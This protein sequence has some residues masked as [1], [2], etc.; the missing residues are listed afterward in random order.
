MIQNFSTLTHQDKA[1]ILNNRVN[2][3]LDIDSSVIQNANDNIHLVLP[4]GD[5]S[6]QITL[7]GSY[8]PDMVKAYAIA[9]GSDS[10]VQFL[11]DCDILRGVVTCK[12]KDDNTYTVDIRWPN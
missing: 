7:T 2:I 1:D 12:R 4:K 5:T 11:L 10:W 8:R 3:M 9:Y 6:R